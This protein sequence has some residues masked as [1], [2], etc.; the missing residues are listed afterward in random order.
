MIKMLGEQIAVEKIKMV[1]R[2]VQSVEGGVPKIETS[3][4]GTG[5]YRQNISKLPRSGRFLK[6]LIVRPCILRD[7]E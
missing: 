6:P 7:K 2:R 1:S 4:T 3:T 5:N